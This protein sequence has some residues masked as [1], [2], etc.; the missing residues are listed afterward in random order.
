VSGGDLRVVVDR[1][2]CQGYGN[3]LDAAPHAF[4]LDADDIAVTR[5]DRFPASDRA[6]LERAVDRCPARALHLEPADGP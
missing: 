6:A 3:C 5:Q 4:D 1:A 2:K